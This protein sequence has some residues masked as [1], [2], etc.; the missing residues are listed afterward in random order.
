M[1]VL[2]VMLFLQML[3]I[4]TQICDSAFIIGCVI[5]SVY[6]WL[7][8]YIRLSLVVLLHPFVE[9]FIFSDHYIFLIPT[10]YDVFT[11]IVRYCWLFTLLVIVPLNYTFY[12]SGYATSFPILQYFLHV[13]YLTFS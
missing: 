10:K 5:T 9:I 11:I 1:D 3:N 2:V 4:V 8:Y 12:L 13:S 6:R 7:C